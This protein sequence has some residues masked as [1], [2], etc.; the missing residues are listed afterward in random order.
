[1]SELTAKRRMECVL[2][3]AHPADGDTV[4]RVNPKGEKGVWACEACYK[5]ASRLWA[6]G[7]IS[8]DGVVML[9]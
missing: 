8:P 7:K 6:K 4:L 1:M 2:C 5:E 9:S 3:P